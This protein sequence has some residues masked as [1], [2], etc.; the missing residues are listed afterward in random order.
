MSNNGTQHCKAKFI[1]YSP[2]VFSWWNIVFYKVKIVSGWS[3]SVESKQWCFRIFFN[4]IN[5]PTRFCGKITYFSLFF[6]IL[7]WY[8]LFKSTQVTWVLFHIMKLLYWYSIYTLFQTFLW[9]KTNQIKQWGA[10]E[11]RP[12][13]FI[14]LYCCTPKARHKFFQNMKNLHWSQ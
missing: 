3:T 11:P 14:V 13:N 4:Y 9:G 6:L 7:K 1:F 2:Y 12:F 10:L 8:N 5:D